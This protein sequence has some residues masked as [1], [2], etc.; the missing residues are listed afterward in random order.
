MRHLVYE[1]LWSPPLFEGQ[2]IADVGDRF[3]G[4]ILEEFRFRAL[5]VAGAE[6]IEAQVEVKKWKIRIDALSA[7]ELV[8]RRSCLLVPVVQMSLCH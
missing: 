2:T 8:Q 4:D 6:I 1:C 5:V 7:P 3:E